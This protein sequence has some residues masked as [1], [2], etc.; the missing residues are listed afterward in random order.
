MAIPNHFFEIFKKGS[1]TYFYSSLL[2]PK[3]VRE[4]IFIL[5]AFVRTTDNFVDTVPQQKK[6]FKKFVK[7]YQTSLVKRESTN[8]IKD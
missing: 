4:D 8:L 1:T 7:E 3:D 5:Y 6:E 2:F